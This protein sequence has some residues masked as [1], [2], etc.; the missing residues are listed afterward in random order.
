MLTANMTLNQVW[1]SCIINNKR[2]D[3]SCSLLWKEKKINLIFIKIG[4]AI[5][6]FLSK[7]HNKTFNL[8]SVINKN[9]FASKS[10]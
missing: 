1:M 10:F 7:V 3:D 4:Y 5:D 8:L 6:N 2:T 9:K